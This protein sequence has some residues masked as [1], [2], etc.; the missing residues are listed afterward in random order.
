MGSIQPPLTA[1]MMASGVSPRRP[2]TNRTRRPVRANQKSR[3]HHCRPAK[4]SRTGGAAPAP[5]MVSAAAPASPAPSTNTASVGEGSVRAKKGSRLKS[6]AAETPTIV[7]HPLANQVGRK[8]P[9]ASADPTE[10][11]SDTTPEGRIASADVFMARNN[12]IA[13][14]AV[15]VLEF[16]LSSSSM[17]L[18]PNGV[19]ALPNPSILAAI[20]RII[21]L[22]AGLSAGTFGKSRCITG[23]RA[24]ARLRSRPASSATRIRPRKKAMSPTRPMARSTAPPADDTMESVRACIWPAKAARR[25]AESAAK[26]IRPFS[27]GARSGG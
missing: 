17:A 10:A 18:I 27:I 3:P 7:A 11:R 16:S 15:P 19:A 24:R 25:T 2:K 12:T 9:T 22:I 5:A 4:G 8:M 21:A 6:T 13:L 1:V 23:P 26:T 14:V 20:L